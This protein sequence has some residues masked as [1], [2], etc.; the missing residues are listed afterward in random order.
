MKKKKDIS[1]K[2]RRFTKRKVL[3]NNADGSEFWQ[4]DQLDLYRPAE[5]QKVAVSLLQRDGIDV[6]KFQAGSPHGSRLKDYVLNDLENEPDS[7]LGLA[8]RIYEICLHIAGYEQMPKGKER[9]V[10]ALAYKL[11]RLLT[12]LSVYESESETQRT[13]AAKPRETRKDALRP[14]IVAAF[15]VQRRDKRSFKEAIVALLGGNGDLQF[16]E[17]GEKISI[18]LD[19]KNGTTPV[20]KTYS[21]ASLQS[22]FTKAAPN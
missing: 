21:Y 1:E 9:A 2:G 14:L 5:A 17:V 3:V 12:L 15:R 18:C 7:P 6:S 13:N 20:T 10:P 19:T 11:G 4:L 22:M 16:S 8:A